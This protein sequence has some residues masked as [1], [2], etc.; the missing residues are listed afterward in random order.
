VHASEG[1]QQD[2]GEYFVLLQSLQCY[3]RPMVPDF[4]AL[5]G[6]QLNA[7]RQGLKFIAFSEDSSDSP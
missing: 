2:D 7:A 6:T 1:Q 5:L 4:V 3:L